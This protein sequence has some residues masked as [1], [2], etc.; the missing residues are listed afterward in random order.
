MKGR[1]YKSCVRSAM[2]YGC[3]TWCLRENEVAILIRTE[4]A[5]MRAMCEVKMIEE[6][7]E[8]RIYEFAGGYFGWSSQGEWSLMF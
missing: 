8:P 4:K 3:M 7:K 2:L 1:I 5:M 6:K